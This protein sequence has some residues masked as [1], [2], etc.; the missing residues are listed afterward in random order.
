MKHIFLEFRDNVVRSCI[1]F[2]KKGNLSQQRFWSCMVSLA[3]ENQTNPAKG[4][5]VLDISGDNTQASTALCLRSCYKSCL[6]DVRADLPSGSSSHWLFFVC[7]LLKTLKDSYGP[8]CRDEM[9]WNLAESS[10]RKSWKGKC[11]ES[12][13]E[14]HWS[15]KLNSLRRILCKHFQPAYGSSFM[16]LRLLSENKSQ[17]SFERN[18]LILVN[19]WFILYNVTL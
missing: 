9:R 8:P 4:W 5:C 14:S 3:L 11:I 18:M 17:T 10:H 19:I 1:N 2:S 16:P 15:W 7:S 12:S 6:R 13:S